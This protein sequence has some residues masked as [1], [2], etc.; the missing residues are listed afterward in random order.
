MR[1]QLYKNSKEHHHVGLPETKFGAKYLKICAT[2][3]A[4]QQARK[5][6]LIAYTACPQ[7]PFHLYRAVYMIDKFHFTDFF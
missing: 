7:Y 6:T 2:K 1:C 4:P 3:Y 5:T